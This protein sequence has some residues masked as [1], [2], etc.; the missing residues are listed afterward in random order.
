MPSSDNARCDRTRI[1]EGAHAPLLVSADLLVLRT[2]VG[3]CGSHYRFVAERF[4]TEHGELA[5]DV[6]RPSGNV[7]S[8]EVA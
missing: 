6:Q 8:T 5:L 4:V 1:E 2:A 3:A 7:P